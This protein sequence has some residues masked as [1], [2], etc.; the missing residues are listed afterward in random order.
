VVGGGGGGGW[1]GGG[2][3]GVGVGWVGRAFW[4]GQPFE[5]LIARVGHQGLGRRRRRQKLL[6]TALR[7]PETWLGRLLSG[8]DPPDA[9]LIFDVSW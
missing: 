5:I 7:I 9:T 1:G 4:T 8:T 6:K 2:W 3:G